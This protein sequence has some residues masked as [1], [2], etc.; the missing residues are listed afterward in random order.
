MN[1][2]EQLANEVRAWVIS[3]AV[4]DGLPQEELEALVRA[5][6]RRPDHVVVEDFAQMIDAHGPLDRHLP[7]LRDLRE[8]IRRWHEGI[9]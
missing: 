2:L 9:N 4:D 6:V 1:E 5:G 3:N 7:S 8:R